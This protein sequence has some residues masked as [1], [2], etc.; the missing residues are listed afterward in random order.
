MRR[1]SLDQNCSKITFAFP[2]P[3]K[4]LKWLFRHF[5]EIPPRPPLGSFHCFCDLAK[6]SSPGV[7][8]PVLLRL[9]LLG[10]VT[11]PCTEF[12]LL[13]KGCLLH[14]LGE[15]T[16]VPSISTHSSQTSGFP[17]AVGSSPPAELCAGHTSLQTPTPGYVD[18]G[19]EWTLWSPLARL[20]DDLQDSS[21]QKSVPHQCSD[22]LQP[23]PLTPTG[24]RLTWLSVLT[25]RFPQDPFHSCPWDL[26]PIVSWSLSLNFLLT[27]LFST[28]LEFRKFYLSIL[29][30]KDTEEGFLIS[31]CYSL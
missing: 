10:P 25:F 23:D 26:I 21:L 30:L 16:L 31:P 18:Q 15:N 7:P 12:E 3:G 22:L 9:S 19:V 11:R 5:H 2:G 6:H 17:R 27:I 20:K 4:Y 14:G 29:L 28:L 24:W 8:R 1:F 13:Q